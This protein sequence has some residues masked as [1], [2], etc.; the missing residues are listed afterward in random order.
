MTGEVRVCIV[1]DPD[2][3]ERLLP[4]SNATPVWIVQS[5]ANERWARA[6]WH[7]G[8]SADDPDGISNTK[9]VTTFAALPFGFELLDWIE[10]HHGL[11]AQD[12]P[13]TAL[14]IIGLELTQE[15]AAILAE[16]GYAETFATH[17][18]FGALRSEAA[19]RRCAR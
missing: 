19:A 15:F 17:S 9:G 1:L 8:A 13:V 10:E 12:P 11:Y 3:G 18:G 5:P 6:V 4:L 7:A 14:E 2:F 16:Y